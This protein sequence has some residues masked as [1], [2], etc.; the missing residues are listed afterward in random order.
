MGTYDRLKPYNNVSTLD[1]AK[2]TQSEVNDYGVYEN[3]NL[4]ETWENEVLENKKRF[5]KLAEEVIASKMNRLIELIKTNGAELIGGAQ[6]T[7]DGV[8]MP[9]NQVLRGI[10][11]KIAESAVGGVP[12]AQAILTGFMHALGTEFG[13]I[14]ETDS[15]GTAL[16]KLYVGIQ[17]LISGAE[18]V[19]LSMSAL[20]FPE[21]VLIEGTLTDGAPKSIGKVIYDITKEE[22]ETKNIPVQIA[23]NVSEKVGGITLG[24]IF[25]TVADE[26]TATVKEATHAESADEATHATSADSATNATN[27]TYA[28]IATNATNA[29][30]ATN[31]AETDFT[32][33]SF[34]TVASGSLSPLE[35][36]KTYLIGFRILVGSDWHF[37][38]LG[39]FHIPTVT[40]AW[41]ASMS[42]CTADGYEV[43]DTLYEGD[44]YIKLAKSGVVQPGVNIYYKEI[45]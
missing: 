3:G 29:V 42:V 36:G 35:Y 22:D 32:N 31:A 4:D 9:I 14:L 5:D 21:K 45:R 18:A 39:V 26:L 12:I 27:A 10:E 23:K 25:E 43:I 34:S 44:R 1:G 2:V 38:N 24:S 40:P 13:E 30:N 6:W 20:T 7:V 8:K 33:A 15:V 16:D 17:G 11:T 41:S 37:K 28:T 19:A